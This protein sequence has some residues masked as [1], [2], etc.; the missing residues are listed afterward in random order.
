[1]VV[2]LLENMNSVIVSNSCSVFCLFSDVWVFNHEVYT[3]LNIWQEKQ[4]SVSFEI[5][6]SLDSDCEDCRLVQ[7]DAM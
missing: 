1:M 2:Y 4:K 5:R 3:L 6:V 7:S